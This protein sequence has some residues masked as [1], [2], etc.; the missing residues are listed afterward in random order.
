MASS[1]HGPKVSWGPG[2]RKMSALA[3]SPPSLW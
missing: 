1:T 2:A 3:Y